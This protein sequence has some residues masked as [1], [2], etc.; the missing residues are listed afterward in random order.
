MVLYKLSSIITIIIIIYLFIYL[1]YLI[2]RLNY[3][4]CCQCALVLLTFR[5]YEPWHNINYHNNNNIQAILKQ[6]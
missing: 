5:A 4:N 1:A 6:F 2:A 3:F